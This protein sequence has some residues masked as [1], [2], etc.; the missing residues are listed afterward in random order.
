LNKELAALESEK[1]CTVI[2]QSFAGL[3]VTGREEVCLLQRENIFLHQ[4]SDLQ[5]EKKKKIK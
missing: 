2:L 4:V 1:R 5:M 3:K